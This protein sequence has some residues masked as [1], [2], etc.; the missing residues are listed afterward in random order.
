MTPFPRM[1]KYRFDFAGAEVADV[2]SELG[3][4]LQESSLPDLIRPGSKVA[5]AVGSRKIPSLAELVRTCVRQVRELG[6]EP[7]IVPAM[8]SHGGATAAG[9][10]GV[11][12]AY[13]ITGV[14]VGAPVL[15]SMEVT[16]LGATSQGVPVYCDILAYESDAI[17]LINMVRPHTNFKGA[18][19]SG[20]MKLLA[21]GLGK[22]KGALAM[23]SRGARNLSGII[24]EAGRL[25]MKKAPVA[26]GVAVLKN[27]HDRICRISVVP[28]ASIE[29]TERKLLAQAK[30][31][32]PRLPVEKLDVLVVGKI[33][34]DIS[35]TGMDTN[36]IGF[37]R[38]RQQCFNGTSGTAI[39]SI[40]VLD[41]SDR[42]HGNACGV[43]M[44]DVITER[45][46]Q[47]IN[48]TV[49]RE[50]VLTGTSPEVGKIPIYVPTDRDAIAAAMRFALPVCG[51]LRMI[52]IK[53]TLDME[54]LWISEGLTGDP[55]IRENPCL[56]TLAG[57]EEIVFDKEGIL[58]W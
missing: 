17:I 58:I 23:H 19:E 55:Q 40:A 30:S 29:D 43:G 49:T 13:G 26:L 57:P 31:I 25:I 15:S 50:N 44:A 42:S 24:V 53:S 28:A 41:L 27:G 7:F 52:M 48:Y 35:G 4:G 16:L 45:L 10:A 9:Q 33:G 51:E 37:D 38:L 54:Y 47:K 6:G 1:A 34:K 21:V 36:V 20:L 11:L 46:Y 18:I 3:R 5:I 32:L 2:G 22:H 12:E 14:S 8:G 56:H 39:S